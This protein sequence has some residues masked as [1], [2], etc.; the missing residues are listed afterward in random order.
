MHFGLRSG[1]I[2]RLTWNDVSEEHNSIRVVAEG[3]KTHQERIVPSPSKEVIRTILSWKTPDNN[4]GDQVIPY[5]NNCFLSN[6]FRQI[7]RANGWSEELTF[8]STRRTYLTRL[9]LCGVPLAM[10]K[11]LAGH[12]NVHVTEKYY[13]QF[14]RPEI[15]RAVSRLSYD[16]D[17]DTRGKVRKPGS[18][19]LLEQSKR[20]NVEGTSDGDELDDVKPSLATFIL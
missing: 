11:E 13:S 20:I 17:S 4:H 2:I 16:S 15:A 7:R 10:A 3:N 19:K 12:S 9:Q 8:H 14:P 1:E 6:K 5:K 18:Q